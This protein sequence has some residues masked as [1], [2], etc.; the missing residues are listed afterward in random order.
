MNQILQSGW[1]REEAEFSDLA[2][3]QQNGP[4]AL[5]RYLNENNFPA[6]SNLV[7]HLQRFM[8]SWLTNQ[9]LDILPSYR[10]L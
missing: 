4:D 5:T 2:H 10:K 1:F 8:H 3:A 9:K 7:F 6:L